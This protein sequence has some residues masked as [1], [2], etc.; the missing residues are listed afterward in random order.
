LLHNWLWLLLFLL[1]SYLTQFGHLLFFFLL[2]LAGF[3]VVRLRFDARDRTWRHLHLLSLRRL[4]RFLLSTL[5]RLLLD[6]GLGSSHRFGL[7]ALFAQLRGL[8]PHLGHALDF[9]L[10]L[11]LA[12]HDHVCL[13]LLTHFGFALL[14]LL[15]RG[16]CL[17]LFRCDFLFLGTSSAHYFK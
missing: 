14:L 15:G 13:L 7:R 8:L 4:R 12:T 10:S 6:D 11:L 16:C 5:E 3:Q 17:A 9:S 1:G 2:S